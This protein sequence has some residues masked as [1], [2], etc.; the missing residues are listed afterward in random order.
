MFK[1]LGG[2]SIV[3]GGGAYGVILFI[4]KVECLLN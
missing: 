1:K 2:G 3:G 4:Q